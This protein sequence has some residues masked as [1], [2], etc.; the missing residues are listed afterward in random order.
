MSKK[1][2]RPDELGDSEGPDSDDTPDNHFQ[3][4]EV[5]ISSALTGKKRRLSEHTNGSEDDDDPE[6]FSRFLRESIVKRDTRAGTQVVKKIKGKQK[7]V[8][9]EVGG[10][11][12]QSMGRH[13]DCDN[14]RNSSHHENKVFTPPCS[15]R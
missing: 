7:V 15:D 14:P 6:D 5:D 4:D 3:D 11:S 8:K 13:I 10:G 1:R 9:G 12:F 2:P